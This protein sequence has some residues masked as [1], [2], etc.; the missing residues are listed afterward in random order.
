LAAYAKLDDIPLVP[1]F[2]VSALKT[3]VC[4]LVLIDDGLKPL[5]SRRR[6]PPARA[7]HRMGLLVLPT[8]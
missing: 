3:I 2:F 7:R 5:V 1:V 6:K 4:D 8:A